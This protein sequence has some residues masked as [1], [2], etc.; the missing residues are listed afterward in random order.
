MAYTA[1]GKLLYMEK[2][3]NAILNHSNV[4]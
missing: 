2:L 1:N 3:A 4:E